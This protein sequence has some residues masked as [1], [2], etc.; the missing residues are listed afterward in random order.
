MRAM[1]ADTGQGR[2]GGHGDAVAY[3]LGALDS[4]ARERFEAHVSGC[5]G[6]LCELEALRP[7]ADQPALSVP[8]A[9]P[10]RPPP[11]ARPPGPDRPGAARRALGR[12]GPAGGG[13]D[14]PG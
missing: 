10:R 13:P 7:A 12:Q 5:P 4:A 1:T 2:E 11:A 9:A 14:D 8:Q 6:C 3:V